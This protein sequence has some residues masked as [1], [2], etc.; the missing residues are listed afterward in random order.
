M[1]QRTHIGL[2]VQKDTIAVAVLR[3]GTL[4]CDERVIANTPEAIRRLLSRRASRPHPE[5]DIPRGQGDAI[6]AH[7]R[8]LWLL[9]IR[10][11]TGNGD[12]V[13]NCRGRLSAHG[14]IAEAGGPPMSQFVREIKRGSCVAAG[15][16]VSLTG[17]LV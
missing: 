17:Q 9:R 8:G 16:L 2:P 3:P 7:V 11:S 6:D 15:Y 14:C 1:K 13:H 12:N 5:S 4:E 10:Q